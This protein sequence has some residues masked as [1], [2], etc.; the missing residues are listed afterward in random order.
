MKI[1]K[2]Y[3]S[4]GFGQYLKSL[5]I[6]EFCE[7]S[8]VIIPIAREGVCG[9]YRID[10][11]KLRLRDDYDKFLEQTLKKEMSVNDVE[12]P[13]KEEY[14]NLTSHPH[15]TEWELY[16]SALEIWQ[17]AEKKVIFVN[18]FHI[19]DAINMFKTL[20]GLSESR[21]GNVKLKNVEI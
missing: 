9:I 2:L 19:E 21:N 15:L 1:D 6:K 17:E 16:E 11:I 14:G 10:A 3:S 4:K 13:N 7:L 18:K 5:T 20:Q 8:G 12:K